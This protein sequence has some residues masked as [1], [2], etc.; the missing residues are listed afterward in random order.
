ML[1]HISSTFVS[2][3]TH[4][5]GSSTL[6]VLL[7]LC[8][9]FDPV[10]SLCFGLQVRNICSVKGVPSEN[11]LEGGFCRAVLKGLL[12]LS[13][14]DPKGLAPGL[15]TVAKGFRFRSLA[16]VANGFSNPS[17]RPLENTLPCCGSP[18]VAILSAGDCSLCVRVGAS[19]AFSS[20]CS[21]SGCGGAVVGARSGAG[22]SVPE[23]FG[24]TAMPPNPSPATCGAQRSIRWAYHRDRTR[25]RR[26]CARY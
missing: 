14:E 13:S 9:G 22:T 2:C 11:H 25:T 12:K 10:M 23:A 4:S 7:V 21:L 3:V 26:G 20:L 1:L 24:F 6:I 8:G 16:G 17:R 19:T 18:R 5:T 15:C